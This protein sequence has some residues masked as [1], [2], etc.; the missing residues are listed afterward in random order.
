MGDITENLLDAI[1]IIADA[2]I[3]KVKFDKTI[4]MTIIDDS[5]ADSGKYLV[6]D[7]NNKFF[8]Y[9]TEVQYRKDDTILVTIPEG[10]YDKQKFIVSKVV[11]ES[12]TALIYV[13]PFQTIIDITNNLIENNQEISY[14]ANKN[15]GYSWDISQI[16][17]NTNGREPIWT[18]ETDNPEQGFSRLGIS[19][20]FQT[21]LTE[22]NTVLGNYGLALEITFKSL[23]LEENNT[24]TKIVTMDS[25]NFFGNI[26]N[27]RA[28]TKQEQVYN[29]NEYIDYPIVSMKLFAYQ[30]NNF[31]DVNGDYIPHQN[32]SKL[33]NSYY[34]VNPNIFITDC[35]VCLGVAADEFDQ[36]TAIIMTSDSSTYKKQI[37]LNENSQ[38]I[39]EDA[40]TTYNTKKIGVR[41]IHKDYTTE[42]IKA[43]QPS[44]FPE[45]YEVRWY[46]YKLGAPSP[47]EFAGAHWQRLC[48]F[49]AAAANDGE[50]INT[51]ITPGSE[52]DL[53]TN[54]L[55]GE[56]IPNVNL[57]TEQLKVIVIKKENNNIERFIA[58]SNILIFTNEDEVPSQQTML[59]ENDL[60]IR[61]DDDERG[62]YFLYNRAGR[63]GKEEDLE[64]RILTAVFEPGQNDV[65][66]KNPLVEYQSIT[67]RFPEDNTMIIPA[68]EASENANK[69][70]NYIFTNTTQVGFFIKEDLNR[71]ASNNTI[72]LTV[73]KD[74]ITYN[75]E[76]QLLFGTAG[77]SGSDYTLF[78]NWQDNQYAF[79]VEKNE[80][81]G[82]VIL[83]DQS[84]NYVNI[85]TD[86]TVK[87]EWLVAQYS[88]AEP[89]IKK[90]ERDIF[91]PVFFNNNNILK[92]NNNNPVSNYYFIDTSTIFNNNKTDYYIFDYINDTFNQIE[93]I[94][95]YTTSSNQ[96]YRKKR[97]SENSKPKLNFKMV[98][99]LESN[100]SSTQRY[101]VQYKDSYILD[102]WDS[103]QETETYYIPETTKELDYS[104]TGILYFNSSEI[105]SSITNGEYSPPELIIKKNSSDTVN[106][107]SLYI[108]KLILSNFGD[109]DLIAYFPVP[110]KH[111]YEKNNKKLSPRAIEGATDV[112]YGTDGETDFNKNPYQI[113]CL[114]QLNGSNSEW[115]RIRHGYN[116]TTELAGYWQI[117]YGGQSPADGDN[118]LPELKEKG[119]NNY[120]FKTTDTDINNSKI[121]YIRSGAGTQANPYVYTIVSSPNVNNINNY[122]ELKYDIP[123]LNPVG[124]YIAE[125]LPYGIQFVC[126]D[127]NFITGSGYP[128]W[129][130]PIL[131]YQ[132]NYP[133]TTLNKWNGKD[134]ETD[135]NQGTI[136]AN[137]F[138]AGRK[139]SDNKF[140]GVVLGDWSRSD[141]DR[142]ITEQTGVYGF[143]HGAMSYALKQ[144]G[145]AF[146]GKDG[147]GRIYFNGNKA[148]IYSAQWNGNVH[149]GML[150]DVDDGVIQLKSPASGLLGDGV[151]GQVYISP[152]GSSGQP[153]FRI[154][155]KNSNN[156]SKTLMFIGNDAYY[157]QSSNFTTG[158]SLDSNTDT[159]DISGD[160]SETEGTADSNDNLASSSAAGMKI[161]L[162][163]SRLTAYDFTLKTTNLR[164]SD[165]SPYLKIRG[166]GTINN[167]S[168]TSTLIYIQWK[169]QL[170]QD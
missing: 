20:S 150:L 50:W 127:T 168:L 162:Q 143:D 76:V 18:Y 56:F 155:G 16:D 148:Q 128:I 11:D 17:F 75:A 43:I 1:D 105:T 53:F 138:A 30:R 126:T 167:N 170:Q 39:D 58:S 77:T 42:I 26:Y 44:E 65:Y 27:F 34:D 55:E 29:L 102:P 79:D 80:L 154:K 125:A 51:S 99:L 41:W 52:S 141:T 110:L 8:A 84:G 64:V 163:N 57:Q 120:Y 111:G 28:Y 145:T 2:K 81:V 137:G 59:A 139:E 67:W 90:E 146:F 165:T 10:D 149:A 116:E 13:S 159:Y 33:D 129:T 100:W 63:V 118:F 103:F 21:K 114:Q 133:S 98:E 74:G 144:D 87:A 6:S 164:L 70:T 160:A 121:Y 46:R 82:Q 15:D 166:T 142:A 49:L 112:R 136:V 32:Q 7:G 48:G 117:I 156:N 68:S 45:G 151:Q 115:T 66:Q 134:I 54:E 91:Y 96:Y 60:A 132:D 12:D 104:G 9:S 147:N 157:L 119:A 101:F 25:S 97:S 89:S 135:T 19:A 124:M 94:N 153:F 14:I 140:S 86:S 4:Q 61:I 158:G 85:P 35:Y 130:Q 72:E 161:D 38:D 3:Q 113:T 71:N 95:T 152:Y 108:V 106:M 83:Y 31:R 93:N 5:K 22:Y 169:H 78:L 92:D 88:G 123:K 24:F 62:K 40:R 69:S 36:D 131:V 23:E 37:Y 47:D 73:I 107:N 122:Y 109:Y